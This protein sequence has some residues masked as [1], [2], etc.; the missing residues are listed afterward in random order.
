SDQACHR[1]HRA[2]SEE[3]VHRIPVGSMVTDDAQILFE[4]NAH[5]L[6]VWRGHGSGPEHRRAAPQHATHTPRHPPPRHA[7]PTP[8]E[9]PDDVDTFEVGER[10]RRRNGST[11]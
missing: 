4:W 11:I 1:E 6:P 3:T 7:A 2:R 10:R 9:P 5:P 8:P